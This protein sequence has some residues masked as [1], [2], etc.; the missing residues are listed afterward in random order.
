MATQTVPESSAVAAVESA[1]PLEQRVQKLEESTSL[2]GSKI[3]EQYQTKVETASKYRARLHGIVL[4]NAFRNLG[5]SDNLDLPT[6]AENVL[7]GWPQANLGFSM[8]QSEIGLELFGPTVAG[9]KTSADI[10]FDFAG[11]FP[12]TGNGVN[13]G[14]VRLQTGSLHLDWKNTSITAGQ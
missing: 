5:N 3:D 14:I 12:S 10:Q 8:R 2:I 4:M 11:G 6:Y 13:F 7:P 1:T 9:A